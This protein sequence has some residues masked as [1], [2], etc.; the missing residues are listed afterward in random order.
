MI[1]LLILTSLPI[2]FSLKGWEYVLFE[3]GSERVY[4]FRPVL[5]LGGRAGNRHLGND[6]YLINASAKSN[7]P[8]LR[9]LKY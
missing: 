6:S 8:V 7:S 1:I 9:M 4:W 5:R 3:L 2:H